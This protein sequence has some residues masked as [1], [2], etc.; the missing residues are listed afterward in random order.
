MDK[1][2]IAQDLT[3]NAPVVLDL[4]FIALAVGDKLSGKTFLI[5]KLIEKKEDGRILLLTNK[6]DSYHGLGEV[7]VKVDSENTVMSFKDRLTIVDASD[8]YDD[9]P[10]HR[11]DIELAALRDQVQANDMIIVDEAYP[12][13]AD[14]LNKYELLKTAEI[15]KGKGASMVITTN[16]ALMLIEKAPVL[17]KISNYMFCLRQSKQTAVKICE[18]FA[19]EQGKYELLR[20]YDVFDF[21]K[22]IF[23][24]AEGDLG[25]VQIQ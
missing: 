24:S 8:L 18:I 20:S 10:N 22:G 25:F 3:T 11:L 14:E 13:M 16:Q 17:F 7:V 2:T 12:F 15:I 21:G 5:R 4:P 6:A 1:L 23:A 19:G 9:D